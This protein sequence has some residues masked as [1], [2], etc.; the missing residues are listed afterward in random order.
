MRKINI[1]IEGNCGCPDLISEE[2]TDVEKKDSEEDDIKNSFDL[3]A[4]ELL[5]PPPIPKKQKK[6]G[7]LDKY[8]AK[9]TKK[10]T[11]AVFTMK[12]TFQE[13]KCKQIKIYLRKNK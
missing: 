12:G 10:G 9:K 3:P 7:F 8:S 1:K 11:G 4:H 5:P 6:K 13:Q 2:D